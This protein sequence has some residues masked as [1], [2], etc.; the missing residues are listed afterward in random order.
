[1]FGEGPRND[2]SGNGEY[3]DDERIRRRAHVDDSWID[4]LPKSTRQ[5]QPALLGVVSVRGE[6][7]LEDDTLVAANFTETTEADTNG[8]HEVCADDGNSN[9]NDTLATILDEFHARMGRLPSLEECNDVRVKNAER[10]IA[11][12]TLRNA[13]LEWNAKNIETSSALEALIQGFY[14]KTNSLPTLEQCNDI[15]IQNGQ[16]IIAPSSFS[17]AI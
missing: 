8:H 14:A 10:T 1:M 17:K 5:R 3:A 11:P 15:R 13:I 16:R 6:L 9:A 4:A 12:G 7:G 2:C